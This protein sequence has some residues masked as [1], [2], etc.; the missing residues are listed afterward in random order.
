MKKS[1]DEIIEVLSKSKKGLFEHYKIRELGIFGS[2]TRGEERTRSDIDMLVAFDE[3]PD[4]LT[5]IELERQL[6][7]FLGKKVDLVRKE[8]LRPVIRERILKEVRYI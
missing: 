3:I 6:R 7:K 1:L 4:L 5:F 8:A 2:L